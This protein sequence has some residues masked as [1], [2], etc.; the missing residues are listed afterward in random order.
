MGVTETA[1][2]VLRNTAWSALRGPSLP[3]G[4]MSVPDGLRALGSAADRDGAARARTALSHAVVHQGKLFEITYPAVRVLAEFLTV[5]GDCGRAEV[6]DLLEE[7]TYGWP[8][9]GQD[10]WRRPADEMPHLG[11]ACRRVV[12][13]YVDVIRRDCLS[14]DVHVRDSAIGVLIAT[15]PDRDALPAELERFIRREPSDELRA[16]L[17]ETLD[18]FGAEPLILTSFREW[19]DHPA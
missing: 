11:D 2:S 4:A 12:G 8:K 7:I 19:L 3:E 13:E 10:D 9:P 17:E 14:E 6:Y 18:D 1:D 15:S 5:P 16:D